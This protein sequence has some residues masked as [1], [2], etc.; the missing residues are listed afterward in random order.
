MPS[1]R[2]DG[3]FVGR[4]ILC[5]FTLVLVDARL[6]PRTW[7]CPLRMGMRLAFPRRVG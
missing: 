2:V 1:K 6:F 5:F 7:A 4:L 3:P